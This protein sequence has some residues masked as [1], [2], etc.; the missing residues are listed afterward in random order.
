MKI[1]I[2]FSYDFSRRRLRIVLLRVVFFC[3]R[4]SPGTNVA[5]HSSIAIL[6]PRSASVLTPQKEKHRVIAFIV[7]AVV[8]S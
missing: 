1:N 5:K 8:S 3:F 2:H 6:H 7:I 4:F